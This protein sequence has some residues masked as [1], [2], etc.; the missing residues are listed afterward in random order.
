MSDQVKFGVAG[1]IGDKVVETAHIADDAITESEIAPNA[2]T[3][4]K[5]G[6]RVINHTHIAD[7]AVTTDQLA[8]E[9]VV[10]DNLTDGAVITD[11]I[12]NASVTA[13]KIATGAVDTEKITSGAI[14]TD[15]I[16]DRVINHTHIADDAVTTDNLADG[17][18]ITDK[19]ANASVTAD[20][21][22]PDALVF[23]ISQLPVVPLDK[24]GTGADNASDAR[25]NLGLGTAA[26]RNAGRAA[27][28]V[29]VLGSSGK[30][31]EAVIPGGFVPAGTRMVFAQAAPPAGWTQDA[32]Y[33]DR[34]LRFVS[35]AGGGTGGSKSVAGG[36]VN[37]NTEGSHNHGG[38]Y[39]GTVS[40]DGNDFRAVHVSGQTV[41]TSQ[42][43]KHTIGSGGNHSHTLSYNIKYRNVIAA[44]KD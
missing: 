6:E 41:F 31:A 18:V 35:G 14:T 9:S 33:N 13:D 26:T 30:L 37:T 28:D 21:I 44:T 43:H 20:K 3:G 24:G 16:G 1:T 11:K 36:R 15:K 22:A 40:E 19:L 2:V 42:A 32:N 5:I 27:G 7:D 25:R 8:N 17:A 12:A 29:P 4:E 23:N 39:T 10:T 34:V 38:G